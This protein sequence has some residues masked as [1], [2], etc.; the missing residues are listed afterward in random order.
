M[1]PADPGPADPSDISL[2]SGSRVKVIFCVA[3][4]LLLFIVFSPFCVA[5][6]AIDTLFVDN[7]CYDDACI[8][9]GWTP[10]IIFTLLHFVLV[11]FVLC[12]L[13]LFDSLPVFI[14][15][16][17]FS[18]IFSQGFHYICSFF[19][20]IFQRVFL[21]VLSFGGLKIVHQQLDRQKFFVLHIFLQASL[22]SFLRLMFWQ[23]EKSTT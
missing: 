23:I 5:D 11:S 13:F 10:H 3:A 1:L 2:F 15:N 17:Y 7:R 20:N 19:F 14:I 12:F 22:S 18:S 16:V 6:K 21:F 8:Q 4:L 9:L